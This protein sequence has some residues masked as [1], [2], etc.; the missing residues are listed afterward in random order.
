MSSSTKE[1]ITFQDPVTKR[2]VH[3]LTN[4]DLRSVHAYYDNPPW[5]PVN[6]RIAFSRL[7]PLATE[8]EVFVM[9]VDGDNL[10]K[11]A[12]SNAMTSND[13]AMVQWSAD[14]DRVYYKARD[15][16][17][18]LIA[19]SD[20]QT[21]ESGSYPGD[22]RMIC[23]TG[24]RQAYHTNCGDF[25]DHEIILKR[26]EHGL[27]VQDLDTGK[28]ELIVTVADCLDIHPRKEEIQNWHLFIKHSKWSPDGMRMMFVF[29]NEIRYCDKY[30]E[31]PRV[32]DVH[33]INADRT[34]LKR[35]GEFGNHPIWHPNGQE[36]LTNSSFQGRRG[37]SLVLTDVETGEQRLASDAMA[38]SGH[39]SFSPDGRRIALDY[40][41]AKEGYGSLNLI[42][43]GTG[44]VEHLVQPRIT[45]HSHVGTHMHPVWSR[46]GRQL[47]YA[48]DATG[49]AQLCVLDV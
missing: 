38:G 46:D 27:Y 15:N 37:N 25:P 23:P 16:G 8:G 44:I 40:V 6:K 41:L 3:Q 21:G 47:M 39:P 17:T 24:N 33:V 36:I 19:W 34:G 29:T 12:S 4:A 35:V 49:T 43:V 2:Q 14:G 10:E 30:A 28:S 7:A 1:A 13:G 32:K 48:S 20:V 18:R 45:D 5:S 9:D 22:L 42:D 31:L 26:A 11:L